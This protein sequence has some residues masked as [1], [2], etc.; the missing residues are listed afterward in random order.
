MHESAASPEEFWVFGYGSLMW[1]GWE[2]ELGCKLRTVAT[3]PG[4]RRTFNK[5]SVKNW[6]TKAAPCPTLNVETDS[7]ASCV[8]MAFAFSQEARDA[9]LAYLR[10]REGKSFRIEPLA[11]RLDDGKEAKAFTPLYD[12]KNLSDGLRL[13]EQVRMI[14]AAKG[15]SGPGL[16]YVRGV[17]GQ[18]KA[19][20]IDDPAVRDLWTALEAS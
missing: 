5:L 15:A 6:G 7:S 12:G 20:G 10:K 9:V 14:R 17:A 1:D 16:E 13:D 19:L 8:G 2:S 18:L 11:I 4:Y 3:L